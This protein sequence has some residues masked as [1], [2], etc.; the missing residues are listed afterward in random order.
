MRL[1]TRATSQD[2]AGE[3]GVSPGTVSRA[4]NGS[5][6]VNEETRR[7]ILRVVEEHSYTPN[8]LAQRFLL[9]KT[10][11]MAVIVPFFTCPSVSER[12][13]GVVSLLCRSQYDLVI[14]NLEAPE[15]QATCFKEIPYK[16][17]VG[18]AG[19]PSQ[20]TRCCQRS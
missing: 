5:P 8:V 6:L 10:L 18:R 12:L 17:Q 1:G 11:T 20:S 13:K 7:R 16:D 14:Q 19:R 2:V 4:T 9:G 3:A 15:Q